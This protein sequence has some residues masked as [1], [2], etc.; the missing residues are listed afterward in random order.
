MKINPLP[1]L[2]LLNHLFEIS[3]TSPSGLVWKNPRSNSVKRGDTAGRINTYG[4]YHVGVRTDKDRNYKTH[5]ILYYM[6]TGE[7]PQD[8]CID[9]ISGRGNNFNIRKATH[10]QNGGNAKKTKRKTSSKYKGV[11][12][13]KNR[14]KWLSRL[15]VERKCVYSEYFL[16]EKEAAIAYNKKA[17]EYF[18]QY[19]LLNVIE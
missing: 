19:A 3:E 15:M 8:F 10:S 6:K 17:L 16:T 2:E 4:Y 1:P 7:D 13:R 5:R 12:R 18:G 14:K 9:H 11:S